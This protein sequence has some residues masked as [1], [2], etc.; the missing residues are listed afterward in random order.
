MSNYV[1]NVC[2]LFVMEADLLDSKEKTLVLEFSESLNEYNRRYKAKKK[3]LLVGPDAYGQL[4]PDGGVRLWLN[5]VK[6]NPY[7]S[8]G[9]LYFTHLIVYCQVLDERVQENEKLDTS[10]FR[11]YI[12]NIEV[13]I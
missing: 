9:L 3:M 4:K 1:I 7:I 8:E 11:K 13:R 12:E 10:K 5:H 6:L 2:D